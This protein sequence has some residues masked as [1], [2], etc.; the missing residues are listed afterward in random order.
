M[1]ATDYN[2]W[3]SQNGENRQMAKTGYGEGISVPNR[4]CEKSHLSQKVEKKREFYL[5]RLG[6]LLNT[7]INV[8]FFRPGRGDGK[9]PRGTGYGRYGGTPPFGIHLKAKKG[10][11]RPKT[12]KPRKCANFAIFR[13]SR[14]SRKN[15][16]R[17]NPG[18]F[19]PGPGARRGGPG[20]PSQDPSQDRFPRILDFREKRRKTGRTGH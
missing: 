19:R 6:E 14:K 5:S 17:K 12:G 7:Q 4:E 13:K 16:Q 1:I 10:H 9:S 2:P 15:A 20:T 3:D 11:F 18:N 8:H